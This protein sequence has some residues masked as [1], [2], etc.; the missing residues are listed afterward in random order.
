MCMCLCMYV[1]YGGWV[2]GRACAH[3]CMLQVTCTCI[4][5]GEG[6]TISDGGGGGG[7]GVSYQDSASADGRTAGTIAFI[8]TSVHA[9]T[10]PHT[11]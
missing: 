2:V 3:V 9:R 11:P 5:R 4:Y 7:G 10:H 6:C 1:C 8:H